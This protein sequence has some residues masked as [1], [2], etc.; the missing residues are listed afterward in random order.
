[1]PNYRSFERRNA[2]P[3]VP[4][5][6]GKGYTVVYS[7]EGI[8]ADTP[9]VLVDLSDAD[10]FPHPADNVEGLIVHGIRVSIE[11][12]NAGEADIYFGVVV[13]ND[14][15]NGTALWFHRINLE[16][17]TDGFQGAI[18]FA[19]LN[20]QV[21][22]GAVDKLLTNI[23]QADSTNWQNDVARTTPFGTAFPGVGDLV[24]FVEVIAGTVDVLF[25][26]DYD[27]L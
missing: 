27:S 19:D 4:W 23:K 12:V 15:S 8:A 21:V 13:E 14:A 1:M 3:V 24:A 25:G 22:N 17:G 16:T 2:Q 11:R 6:Y 9:L 18:P 10:N 5:D 7:A 20:L 26:I